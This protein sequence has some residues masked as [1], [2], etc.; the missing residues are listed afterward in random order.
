MNTEAT[1]KTIRQWQ[2]DLQSIN[3]VE[4]LEK[5]LKKEQ[6][7]EKPR[8]TLITLF[9]T[10]IDLLTIFPKGELTATVTESHTP[11]I[12]KPSNNIEDVLIPFQDTLEKVDINSLVFK[13]VHDKEGYN[14]IKKTLNALV[15]L[16]TNV[17]TS[18]KNLNAPLSAIVSSNNLKSSSFIAEIKHVESILKQRRTDYENEVLRIKRIQEDEKAQKLLAEQ[19]RKEELDNAEVQKNEN[20]INSDDFMSKYSRIIERTKD[21]LSK[22]RHSSNGLHPQIEKT[23]NKVFERILNDKELVEFRIKSLENVL[24]INQPDSKKYLELASVIDKNVLKLINHIKNNI[25]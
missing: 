5:Y 8:E 1:K 7:N 10:R 11:L 16:R 22:K 18:R 13:D 4:V 6:S 17:D 15:K 23:E 9:K 24:K 25:D 12:I 20:L 19:K 14:N 21:S 2:I 3:Q